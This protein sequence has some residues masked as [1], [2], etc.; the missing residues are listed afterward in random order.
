MRG[1]LLAPRG[2]LAFLREDPSVAS[3][4][5][6]KLLRYESPLHV[7]SGG[8]R[9][10]REPITLHDVTLEPGAPV[11]LLLGSANRDPAVFD[12]PDV[13]DFRRDAK[14]HLAFG[15]GVHF[16]LGAALGRL[17]GQ[18]VPADD[19]RKGKRFVPPRLEPQ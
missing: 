8:G 13:L 16:C 17:E 3:R 1:L 19:A 2:D 14:P 7:A 12:D 9:W 18:L 11:R 15:K 6:E 10:A 5:I 4:A